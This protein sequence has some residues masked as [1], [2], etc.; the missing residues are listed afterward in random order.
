MLKNRL[1]ISISQKMAE[2]ALE[3]GV[4]Q[5]AQIVE[6]KS[7][8]TYQSALE[9]KQIMDRYGVKDALLVTSAIHMKRAMLTFEHAGI[10]VYPAPVS[11]FE[12]VVRD[13]LD[14]FG[15]FRAVMREYVGLLFY[16]WKGWT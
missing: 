12:T 10:K 6:D 3:L 14:R 15:M 13:P 1:D 9:V 16:R 5:D 11:H 7:L 8:R 4:P 2:L